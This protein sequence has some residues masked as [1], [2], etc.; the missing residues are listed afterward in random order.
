MPVTEGIVTS[1][2]PV[3]RERKYLNHFEDIESRHQRRL[4]NHSWVSIAVVLIFF[5]SHYLMMRDVFWAAVMASVLFI[6]PLLLLTIWLARRRRK[7]AAELAL[8]TA[9]CG[10]PILGFWIIG[11]SRGDPNVLAFY[12]LGIASLMCIWCNATFGIRLWKPALCYLLISGNAIAM[13]LRMNG[14]SS[15]SALCLSLL[16]LSGAVMSLLANA[17]MQS[18]ERGYVSE[19]GRLLSAIVAGQHDLWALDIPTGRAEV[20]WAT[21]SGPR[22]SSGLEYNRFLS[23]VHPE[24][25]LYV[26]DFLQN[27]IQQGESHTPCQYRLRPGPKGDCAWYEGIGK[28]VEYDRNG[29]PL[30]LFGIT[31]NISDQKYL[32]RKLEQQS[33]E[34]VR[35]TRAKSEFLATMSHE[36]R[37]P[38]NGI[39]GMASLVGEMELTGDQRR[40]VSIVQTSGAV[41]LRTLNDVLDFS[42]I[43]AGKLALAKTPFELSDVVERSM[44]SVEDTART[45]SLAT[46]LWISPDISPWLQGD[47]AQL[48]KVLTHLLSNAVKFTNQGSIELTVEPRVPLASGIE[49]LRFAVRDTGPGIEPE[50]QQRLYTPFT[51]GHGQGLTAESGTGLGLAISKCI[52][53]AMGGYIHCASDPGRGTCFTVDLS[54]NTCGPPAVAAAWQSGSGRILVAED[55]PVNQ[56]VIRR[57]LQSLG[58]S[59]TIVSDGRAAVTEAATGSYD[60]VLMDYQM[61]ILDGLES[62][63]LIRGLPGGEKLPI[64]ALTAHGNEKIAADCSA[65]GVSGYLSKPIDRDELHKALVRWLGPTKGPIG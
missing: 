23:L 18:D 38:L 30:T 5:P 12:A 33:E 17:F 20:L 36:V 28:V 39:L 15:R 64:I 10:M 22:R 63:H 53:E 26:R 55:N 14:L 50:A 42:K 54:F 31:N 32:T 56:L 48:G 46:I 58:Y 2:P 3:A 16:T 7:G 21:P 45:K 25:R 37:T 9:F 51:Q 24:D 60:M 19:G 27:C 40:L 6:I 8:L 4:I 34:I 47:G 29:R 65:G 52:V 44:R 57:M 35:A 61:P 49:S 13:F 62:T 1:N 43:E 41:L 59:S 11:S